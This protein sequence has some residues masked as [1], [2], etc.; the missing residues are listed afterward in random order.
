MNDEIP[1][2]YEHLKLLRFFGHEYSLYPLFEAANQFE[3]M[4]DALVALDAIA[5][6]Y[7][8]HED[9]RAVIRDIVKEALS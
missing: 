3:K 1:P 6:E 9:L 8:S 5:V 4:R 7:V 2:L